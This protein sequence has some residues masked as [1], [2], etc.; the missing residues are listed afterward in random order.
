MTN[1]ITN[2][3]D[4]KTLRAKLPVERVELY[5]PEHA[6][7]YSHHAS[8]TFYK[9][10]FYAI[11][12]NGREHEDYPGQRVLIASAEDFAHWTAPEPL[13]GPLQGRHSELV[14]TAAGF[15]QHEGSADRVLRPI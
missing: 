14:L 5:R 3:Y 10:R 1:P 8:S 6:W 2:C 4:P 15:H 12:S 7:T 9:G 13:V 11:W